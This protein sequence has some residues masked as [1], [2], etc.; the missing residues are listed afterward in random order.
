MLFFQNHPFKFTQLLKNQLLNVFFGCKTR[1]RHYELELST[2]YNGWTKKEAEILR[3][4]PNNTLA[5]FELTIE[6]ILHLI[7]IDYELLSKSI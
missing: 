6:A 3:D 7:N 4:I 1:I 2:E 5:G